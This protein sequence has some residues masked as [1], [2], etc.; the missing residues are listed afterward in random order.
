[1]NIITVF[2]GA[3]LANM[4]TVAML[5]VAG[6]KIVQSNNEEEKDKNIDNI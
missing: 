1:M 5:I 3:F 4:T 6:N 2:I